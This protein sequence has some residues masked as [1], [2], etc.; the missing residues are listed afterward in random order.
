MAAF[1]TADYYRGMWLM[2]RARADDMTAKFTKADAKLGR[3][4]DV[5]ALHG[6]CSANCKSHDPDCWTCLLAKALEDR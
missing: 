4:W 6:G 2:A 3:I 5:I 1:G